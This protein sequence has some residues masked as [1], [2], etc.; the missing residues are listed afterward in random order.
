MTTAPTP[1]EPPTPATAED[2]IGSQFYAFAG[3]NPREGDFYAEPPQRV[4]DFDRDPPDMVEITRCWEFTGGRWEGF[5]S[6][7]RGGR[8]GR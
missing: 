5:I 7:G 1:T 4:P 2:E 3:R 8:W 6:V